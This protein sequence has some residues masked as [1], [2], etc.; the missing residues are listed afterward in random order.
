MYLEEGLEILV[1]EWMQLISA[2]ETVLPLSGVVKILGGES[3]KAVNPELTP[4][5]VAELILQ[6]MDRLGL[7]NGAE[8]VLSPF[9][10]EDELLA[11][12]SLYDLMRES[13]MPEDSGGP[14]E[15]QARALFP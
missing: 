11:E 14:R 9:M 3:W 6:D 7:L 8:R 10:T 1:R 5:E 15:E 2:G 12:T 4:G 13:G